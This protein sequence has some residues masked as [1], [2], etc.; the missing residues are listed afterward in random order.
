MHLEA[1][2]AYV[3]L[4]ANLG[5][6]VGAVQQA[7]QNLGSIPHTKLLR[8]S[9]LYQTAPIDSIGPDYINAVAEVHTFLSAPDLL[10]QLQ[11]QELAAGRQRPY[12]NAPRTL[13]LDILLYGSAQMQSPT[14]NVP[15]LRMEQRAFVLHPLAEIASH[16]VAHKALHAVRHQNIIKL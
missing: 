15:H 6:A 5:D 11:A 12:P 1:V 16:R 14:L 4:G 8:S 9:S 13:D 10:K 3:G 7:I 2:V